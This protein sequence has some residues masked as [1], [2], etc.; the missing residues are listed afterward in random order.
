MERCSNAHGTIFY[1]L[2]SIV[3]YFIIFFELYG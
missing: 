2:K 3:F 1:G